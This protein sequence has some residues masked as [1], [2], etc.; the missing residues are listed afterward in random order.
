MPRIKARLTHLLSKYITHCTISPI[1]FFEGFIL[2]LHLL[3]LMV[4][5]WFSTQELF[6]VSSG[7]N[8][9]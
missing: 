5:S 8:P 7:N 4:Y 9:D 2:G 3:V 6:L 1:D